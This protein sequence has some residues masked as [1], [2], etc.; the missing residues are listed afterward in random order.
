[1]IIIIA[2]GDCIICMLMKLGCKKYVF[3]RLYQQRISQ[4]SQIDLIRLMTRYQMKNLMSL[5]DLKIGQKQMRLQQVN[6][7]LKEENKIK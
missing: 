6:S 5:I 4:K 2:F 3:T 7:K 1:L